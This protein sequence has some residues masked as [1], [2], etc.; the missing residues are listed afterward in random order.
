M[1]KFSVYKIENGKAYCENIDE[2]IETEDIILN[3]KELPKS[4]KENDIIVIFDTGEIIVDKEE[5]EK[6]QKEIIE[7]RNNIY[8]IM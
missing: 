2:S 5:T 8:K 6:R 7:L 4:I 1:K 3:I